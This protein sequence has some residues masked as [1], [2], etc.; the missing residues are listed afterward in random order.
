MTRE[1]VVKLRKQSRVR[2]TELR[3]LCDSWLGMHDEVRKSRERMLELVSWR[4]GLK[5]TVRHFAGK[6]LAA[7]NQ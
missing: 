1:E 5:E 2:V 6:L 4:S 3:R 7:T